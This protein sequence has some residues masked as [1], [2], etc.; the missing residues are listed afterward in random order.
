MLRG[1]VRRLGLCSIGCMLI[2]DSLL[3]W[4]GMFVDFKFDGVY[5]EKQI[6]FHQQ[7]E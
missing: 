2:G 3:I 5:V 7:A 4:Y 6:C 1:G